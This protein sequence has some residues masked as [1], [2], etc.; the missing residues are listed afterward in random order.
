VVL[1]VESLL[2]VAAGIGLAAATGFRVF[3]P[4]LLAGIAARWGALPLS[5][6]FQW[7]GSTEALLA[8]ATASALE[9]TGYYIPG[10]DHVLDVLAA[11]A[12]LIAG[13]IASASV[14]VDIPPGVMWPVAII[15]GSGIA[16]LTK[17]TSALFR[18]KAALSTAG[19]ANPV[20]STGETVGVLWI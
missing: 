14:M 8:L 4:F 9:V 20:V 5:D 13:A 12:V 3:L 15:G 6:G 19:V 11:P 1:P 10:V 18:G 2:G 7:L 16:A 17:V